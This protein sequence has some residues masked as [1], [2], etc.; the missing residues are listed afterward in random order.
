MS[1]GVHTRAW[2][3]LLD[4]VQLEAAKRTFLE[5]HPLAKDRQQAALL[6]SDPFKGLS[7][8]TR[9]HAPSQQAWHV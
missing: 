1:G 7:E 5:K 8:R 2:L 9:M 3:W 6:K 4:G